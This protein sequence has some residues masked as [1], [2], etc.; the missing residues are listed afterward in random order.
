MRRTLREPCALASVVLLL[1]LVPSAVTVGQAEPPLPGPFFSEIMSDTYDIRV[2]LPA[3]YESEPEKTYPL[4]VTLDANY[5]FD[6]TSSLSNG[7]Q[8]APNGLIDV[9]HSLVAAELIPEIILVGVGYPGEIL[10]GRDFHGSPSRFF[11]FLRSE[12]LETL[13]HEFRVDSSAGHVLFGHSSGG[14]FA[15]YAFLKAAV[16]GIQSFRH[17]LAIS[18]DYTRNENILTD[19]EVTLSRR[20]GAGLVETGGSLFLAY[21]G[22]EESR[23]QAPAH[24]LVDRLESRGYQGLRLRLRSFPGRDH[25][26]VVLPAVREGLRWTIGDLSGAFDN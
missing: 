6:S 18:G 9:V 12:L 2:H 5:W 4:V 26:T 24:A 14:F 8:I 15:A 16:Y 25:G 19:L 21:G 23:F 17:V 11:T 1:L 3:T 22:M 13:V 10:R 20:D 7:F